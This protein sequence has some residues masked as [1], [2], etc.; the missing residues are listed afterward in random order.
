M[1]LALCTAILGAL[2]PLTSGQDTGEILANV[3]AAIGRGAEG[4]AVR[5]HGSMSYQGTD[6]H[7]ELIYDG[8]G[9]FLQR[10]EGPVPEVHG[11]D[12]ETAWERDWNDSPR[13]L[14]FGDLDRSI[15]E[16][17]LWTGRW[18]EPEVGLVFE[19]VE[20]GS[21]LDFHTAGGLL[22][23]RIELDRA[24]WL[25]ARATWNRGGGEHSL[26]L[27]GWRD[28][29]GLRVPAVILHAS[30]LV[31]DELRVEGVEHLAEFPGAAPR[32][33]SPADTRFDP[34]R[35]PELEV[36]R[37]RTGHLIVKPEIDGEDIGWFIFDTGAGANVISTHVAPLLEAETFG[38]TTARGL[39][40]E[41]PAA[42]LRAGELTVGPAT[43]ADPLFVTMDLEFLSGPLGEEI[44]GVIG[45]GLIAR[46]VVEYDFAHAGIRLFEP[47]DYELR[48]AAWDDVFLYHRHPHVRAVLEGHEGLYLID[49]GNAGTPLI[50]YRSA[51]ERF[52]LLEGR[53]TRG[54][55]SGGVGGSVATRVG[56]VTSLEFA[57]RR[58]EAVDASFATEDLGG[59]MGN[60][61]VDGNVGADLLGTMTMVLDYANKR[62]AFQDPSAGN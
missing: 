36:K 22:A 48:G 18:T 31:P 11:Y 52:S 41:I 15:V 14:E 59:V 57:G 4:G 30:G 58:F 39:G 54:G 33:E 40:G 21:A 46:C 25:P 5:V 50:V 16:T 29:D 6:A 42:F 45:Y 62:I 7:Y 9:R 12:G 55:A 37:T 17:A 35:G 53:E 26:E 38:E 27:S 8:R 20:G 2:A 61:Y 43:I 23:G 13:V 19:G 56:T 32:L 51:V 1:R 24:T 60:P 28:H 10:I 49:T 3:R 44:G 47:A 34:S